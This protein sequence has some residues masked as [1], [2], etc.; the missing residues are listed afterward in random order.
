MGGW[1]LAV[2]GW[3]SLGSVLKGRPEQKQTWVLKDSPGTGVF[4]N[5]PLLPWQTVVA[6]LQHRQSRARTHG[7]TTR[8]L[9]L[10]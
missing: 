4:Q 1:R 3:W 10:L 5:E 6:G 8:P 7:L 2:G 9:T